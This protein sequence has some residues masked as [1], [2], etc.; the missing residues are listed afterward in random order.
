MS[1]HA[2][3]DSVFL[4]MDKLCLH[5]LH[6]TCGEHALHC[7]V[8]YLLRMN[9]AKKESVSLISMLSLITTWCLTLDALIGTLVSG[10]VTRLRSSG[11]CLACGS[12]KLC[13]WSIC[14][15]TRLAC[16][17]LV[18]LPMRSARDCLATMQAKQEKKCESM[19]LSEPS[20]VQG[21][22]TTLTVQHGQA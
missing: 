13:S 12:Q 2:R 5:G 1:M 10:R 19:E 21:R 4:P 8:V 11:Q 22:P 9:D 7:A 18:H 3:S 15:S 20:R 17:G 14:G 16:C 6:V